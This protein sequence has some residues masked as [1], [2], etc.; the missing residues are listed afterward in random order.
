MREIASGV[1]N[2]LKTSKMMPMTVSNLLQKVKIS[3]EHLKANLNTM[4]QSVG[5]TKQ[6][7]FL[8]K[9]ELQ[10]MVHEAGPPTL[11]LT[12]SC[13]KYESPDIINYL[14]IINDVPHSYNAG[15]LCTEDLISVSRQFSSKFHAFFISVVIKGEV[16]DT[17]DHF[18]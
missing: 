2:L 13:A 4:L 14:K 17:V 12:F 16:V 5:G 6:Y 9:S 11:F 7:W 18:Y 8:R 10:C 1:Y 15:K 3:D